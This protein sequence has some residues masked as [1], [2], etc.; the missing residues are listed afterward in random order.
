MDTSETYIKMCEKAEEIQ[1][2]WKP[3]GGDFLVYDYRGTTK[4]SREF[5]KKVWGDDDKTWERIEIL[6]YQPSELKDWFI[7]TTGEESIIKSS[8]DLTREHCIWLP[9][10]DQL[11]EMVYAQGNNI[12]TNLAEAISQFYHFSMDKYRQSFTSM[13]QLWLAFVMREKYSK[14]WDGE[15]WSQD[16]R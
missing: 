16:R 1:K 6:C 3:A 7:S 8:Q 15:E 9:R 4:T 14:V 13:E 11:Q 12:D 10:Q 2:L 5:E